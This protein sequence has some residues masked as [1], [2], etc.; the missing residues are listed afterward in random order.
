MPDSVGEFGTGDQLTSELA[1]TLLD[2][3][4]VRAGAS[5]SAALRD[6]RSGLLQMDGSILGCVDRAVPADTAATDL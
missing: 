1:G 4:G 3:I 5:L 6:G 2:D